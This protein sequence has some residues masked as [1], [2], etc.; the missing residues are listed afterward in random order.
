VNG[1]VLV[2]LIVAGSVALVLF[3]QLL[4]ALS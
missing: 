4:N 1:K 2:A 3:F